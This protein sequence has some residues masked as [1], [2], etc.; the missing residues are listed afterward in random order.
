MRAAA[1]SI[2]ITPP[3]G[4][5]IGGNVRADNTSRGIHDNLYC[6]AV[7][8]EDGMSRVCML[9]LDLL[10]LHYDSCQLIKNSICKKTGISPDNIVINA[11]H[12]H[13]GPDVLEFFKNE[14]DPACLYYINNIAKRIAEGIEQIIDKTEDVS[15]AIS[16]SHVRDL[17]FNRRIMAK[18][19][20]IIMNW[21]YPDEEDVVGETGPIDEE[22]H[23]I[24]L[25]NEKKDTV[26]L[27]INFTLH[28]AVL[29]G[30]DWLWSRDYINYL[31]NYL[32]SELGKDVV[33]LFANGAEGNINH[34]NFRDKNQIRGFEEAKRIGKKLGGYVMDALEGL[35]NIN[36]VDLSCVSAKVGFPLRNISED[37]V[38]AAE[39]L[40]A[41]CNGVIPSL[42]DGCPDE[43][44]ARE[45]IKITGR[46][47]KYA[48]TELQ[49][50][51]L[52]KDTVIVTYPGEVFVE[53]GLRTK[54][55]SGYKNTL[56]FGLANDCIGYVPTAEAF[57]Q[58][59]YEIKT[60]TSSQLD[61][62]A[63]DM[64]VKEVDK[65]LKRL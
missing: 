12:T 5:P 28:P 14:I 7:L 27:I 18:E 31:D 42:I 35:E 15:I 8:L 64:L 2:D 41:E 56:V 54:E 55:T 37:E 46:K 60:A 23:V 10:G 16:K 36:D 45:I 34:I 39:K 57:T 24:S 32:K 59:G 43:V 38:K 25:K 40:W 26:A 30:Q 33:V 44:Y 4:L 19:G 20:G 48:V 51:K 53:F 29:V 62:T 11:T 47:E 6:N 50:V 21:M 63:G 17:S 61:P 13:S 52:S 9:N 22:L 3:V 1:L 58:G 49:A 65:L